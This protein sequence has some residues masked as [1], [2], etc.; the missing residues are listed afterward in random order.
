MISLN[1]EH[2]RDFRPT[3]VT[4]R[5]DDDRRKWFK[6]IPWEEKLK[7]A[8]EQRKLV[9]LQNLDPSLSS[10]ENIIWTGFKER[11]TAKVI[12]K[13]DYTSPHSGQAFA[14]FK[15]MET[16]A[17]VVREL[18]E[19]CFLLSNGLPLVG[20]FGIP[21]VPEEASILWASCC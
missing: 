17:K 8:F 15:K 9:L 18:D 10:S 7:T 13:N 20:S 16:A 5:P 19:G 21:V 2:E 11:C 3:E 12:Q 14:I 1:V 6:E 4:R